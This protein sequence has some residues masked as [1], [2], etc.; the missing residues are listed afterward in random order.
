MKLISRHDL[1]KDVSHFERVR[2]YVD[3]PFFQLCQGQLAGPPQADLLCGVDD[4]LEGVTHEQAGVLE[5]RFGGFIFEFSFDAFAD[6]DDLM[7]RQDHLLH[8]YMYGEN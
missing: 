3:Q 1:E 8:L 4:T 2:C 6:E 5:G 7:S